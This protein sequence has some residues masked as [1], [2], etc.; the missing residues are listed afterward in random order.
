MEDA[1]QL[2]APIRRVA[3]RASRRGCRRLAVP[4]DRAARK[5]FSTGPAGDS[6]TEYVEF[7]HSRNSYAEERCARRGCETA[8]PTMALDH[9][10]QPLWR[11]TIMAGTQGPRAGRRREPLRIAVDKRRPALSRSI[12]PTVSPR[13]AAVTRRV[14][15]PERRDRRGVRERARREEQRAAAACRGGPA[16]FDEACRAPLLRRRTP[17]AAALRAARLC[18]R[19]VP[20]SARRPD[21]GVGGRARTSRPKG[22]PGSSAKRSTWGR[23]RS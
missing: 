21:S 10:S 14:V 23:G 12:L 15:V 8:R 3:R 6:L 4:M 22:C 17:P 5:R 16:S 18:R 7:R 11:P 19:C 9:G 2:A 20:A 1:G 13:P